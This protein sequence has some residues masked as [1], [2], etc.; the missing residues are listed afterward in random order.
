MFYCVSDP[1]LSHHAVPLAVDVLP[2]P[3]VG[4]QVKVIGEAHNFGQSLE[5][6]YAES[7]AA[8]LHGPGAVQQQ[9]EDEDIFSANQLTE[10]EIMQASS[11][12]AV[13]MTVTLLGL[14]TY[15]STVVQ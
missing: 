5:D 2:V 3:P 4:H 7:F 13:E 8:V 1:Y 14:R 10:R 11:E 12:D 6:V 15:Q 9:T